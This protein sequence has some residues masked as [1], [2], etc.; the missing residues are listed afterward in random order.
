[1]NDLMKSDDKTL[2]AFLD[3]GGTTTGFENIENDCISIPFLR[4][5]QSNTPQVA[6]PDDKIPGLEAGMYF[7]PNTGRIYGKEPKFV[8]L[9][10]YRTW[11]VWN[12]EPPDAKFVRTLSTEEYLKNYEPKTRR[13][14]KGKVVD[15]DGNRYV[16]SRNFLL[17][18]ADFPE[19]GILLYPMS[20]TGIPA[21]KKWLAKASA[22]RVSNEEGKL[23]QPPMWARVWSP[24]VTY[25]KNTKGSFYQVSDVADCGWIPAAIATAVRE[26]FL[27]AQEYDKQRISQVEHSDDE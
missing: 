19:D 18:S 22:V 8:I 10:F 6:N 27:N 12:G 21:S 5:A 23:I 4:L 16:D 7:N 17:C 15:S 11:N 24:K 20:S 25:Q 13:D 26:A 2:P 14:E 9:A 3:V 1:M